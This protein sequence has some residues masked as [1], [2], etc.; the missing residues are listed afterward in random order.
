MVDEGAE[1]AAEV[2]GVAHGTV[3]VT[4]NGLGDE[5]SEVVIVLPANTLDGKGN[6]SSG[7]GVI[8]DSH[9]RANEV[10]SALLLSSD[11]R[12]S[13]GVR[14]AGKVSEVLLSKTDELVMGDTAGTNENHA[15]SGVVGLD[16]VDQVITLD[17][18]DVLLG[19]E[20]GAA[21][22]LVLESSGMQVV[23]N[24]LLELLVNLLLLTQNHISLP[25]DSG[26]LELR[27]LEDIGKDV[28][29]LWNIGVE[30]LGVVDSV[31]ALSTAISISKEIFP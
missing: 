28:D 26:R 23:E 13:G 11:S 18:L 15:V 7:N 21:E 8:T 6:V 20:D 9:F 22:R 29:G 31:F 17:A 5:S 4:D 19:S 30:G 24:N 25:L 14:L 12:G 3:P 16:V 1:L 2:R 27:V 10:G